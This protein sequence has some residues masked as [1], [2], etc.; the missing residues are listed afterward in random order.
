[1]CNILRELNPSPQKKIK[2]EMAAYLISGSAI[3]DATKHTVNRYP[4]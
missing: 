1:M 4:T 3:L 2:Q